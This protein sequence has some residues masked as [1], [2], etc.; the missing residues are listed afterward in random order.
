MWVTPAKTAPTPATLIP[1]LVTGIQSREVFRVKRSFRIADATLLDSC[2]EH[3]NEG[4]CAGVAAETSGRRGRDF[5][6]MPR[7]PRQ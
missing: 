5:E 7:H 3:R 1:V 4:G 6:R 2:D